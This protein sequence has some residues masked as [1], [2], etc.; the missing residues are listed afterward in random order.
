MRS[1]RTST[2]PN[3]RLLFDAY[4]SATM[5]EKLDAVL[6]G[7]IDLVGHIHVAD[8]PGRNEPGMGEIDWPRVISWLARAGYRGRI[9]LEYMPSGDSASSLGAIA[10]IVGAR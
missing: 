10:E 6:S 4:H 2:C 9:G 8:V 3:V 5:G 7:R 1:S